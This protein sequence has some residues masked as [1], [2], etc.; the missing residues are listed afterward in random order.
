MLKILKQKFPFLSKLNDLL[1]KAEK[2]K[3]IKVL[4]VDLLMGIFQAVGVLSILPFMN[5]VMD[6]TAVE[7]SEYLSYFYNTLGFSSL[8]I[9]MFSIGLLVLG[10]LIVGNMVSVLSVKLKTTFIWDLNHRISTS[11]LGKYLSLPYSYFLNHNSADLGKN[12]LSEVNQLTGG[13]LMS[14]LKIVEGAVIVFILFLTLIIVNPVMTIFALVVLGAAYVLIYLI[15]SKRLK[16]AG[17]VRI[18]KNEERFKSVG[19]A[20]GGIKFIKVLGKESYSLESYNKVAK[21]FFDAQSWYSIIG[22]VPKYIMEII[23]FGGVLGLVLYFIYSDQMTNE[24]IPLIGLFAFAGYRLMPALQGI[25]SSFTMFRF[26]QPVLNK[27]HYDMKEGGLADVEVDFKEDLPEQMEFNKEIVLEKI[28]FSYE[29]DRKSVLEDINMKIGKDMS[30]GIVGTTGSGKTTLVDIILGLLTPT[31]GNIYIDGTKIT[32]DNVKNW[33]A[34][35]GY[36]PQEI[37]LCDDTIKKNIAFGYD[38]EEIDMER[39]KRVSRMA[40]IN[41]LIEKELPDGYDTV[42]GERGVR[43]S[44]GQR[45]RI[46]IARALYHDPSVLIFDEATSSLDN[47][48]ERGVLKAIES[49][50]KLKTMIV[51]AHRLTTV[52]NCDKIYLIDKG[53]VIDKGKYSELERRNEKFKEMVGRRS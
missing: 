12:I 22:N 51:I 14:L 32:E 25:Y 38:D 30:I 36:V 28:S 17:R 21:E 10:L 19:E 3:L 49:V 7:K 41:E 26:Y 53:R 20:I 5:M 29:G 31:E 50:S 44:G 52:K 18:A 16:R 48:T 47:V 2:R 11:L 34:N 24:I 23:A 33:Q 35:L 6:P 42:I 40:N 9:F 46:G 39:V 45:Q 15:F 13:F 27:I 37:F 4:I 8:N 43:L 1:T